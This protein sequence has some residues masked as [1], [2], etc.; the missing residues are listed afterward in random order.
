MCPASQTCPQNLPGNPALLSHL[1]E[2]SKN[3]EGPQRA[4]AWSHEWH[5]EQ[6]PPAIHTVPHYP[7]EIHLSALGPCNVG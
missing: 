1:P 7:C 5:V 6:R 2:K 4:G 3:Q